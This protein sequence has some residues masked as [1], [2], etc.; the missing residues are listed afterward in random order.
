M[1]LKRETLNLHLRRYED[2]ISQISCSQHSQE[3]VADAQEG[4]NSSQATTS[5]T[6]SGTQSNRSSYT[7]TKNGK[8][9]RQDQDE[10]ENNEGE[11]RS[12]K[13]PKNLLSP[14]R[15]TF[16]CRKFAC[17]YR[18]HDARKYCVRNWRSCALTPLETVAR[19]K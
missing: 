8:R 2:P 19:V 18:K 10:N 7:V 16:G 4:S 1:T 14:P 17:P 6:Y 15:N 12:P 5:S 9:K 11:N 13:R 3:S